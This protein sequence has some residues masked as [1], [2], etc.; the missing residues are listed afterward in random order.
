MH[1]LANRPARPT[2]VLQPDR[3]P[4]RPK[5][6]A[7]ALPARIAWT[8]HRG[9]NRFAS[10]VTRDI[11]DCGVFVEC[12]TPLSIPLYRI[13]QFQLE[14]TV[15]ATADLPE[16]LRQGRVFSAVYRVSPPSK[17]APA[18]LALRLMIE[19][20]RRVMAQ[21]NEDQRATA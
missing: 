16:A 18:G 9:V 14:A 5:R 15:R 19:P 13:V 21:Q 2:V 1:T 4:E 7:I 8:D 3:G 10:V 20:K 11:S 12:T 17:S 6:R